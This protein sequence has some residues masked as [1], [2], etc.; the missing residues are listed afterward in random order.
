MTL[1]V[2]LPQRPLLQLVLVPE[3]LEGEVLET[4]LVVN[5]LSK[6]FKN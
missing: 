4:L 1:K 2:E 5:G 3:S 6:V